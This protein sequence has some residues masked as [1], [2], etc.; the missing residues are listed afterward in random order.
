MNNS[1]E[2]LGGAVLDNR[3]LRGRYTSIRD[4]KCDIWSFKKN[5][6]IVKDGLLKIGRKNHASSFASERLSYFSKVFLLNVVF[7][8]DGSASSDRTT[9]ETARA[10]QV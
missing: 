8:L 6:K 2:K 5:M 4:K 1:P 3:R 10:R 7:P 9:G